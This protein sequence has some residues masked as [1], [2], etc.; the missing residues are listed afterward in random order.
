M[1]DLKPCPFCGGQAHAVWNAQ[2]KVRNGTGT[3]TGIGVCIYCENCDAEIRTT[4][5][6][7]AKEMWNRRAK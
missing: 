4:Q 2:I 1:D 5:T 7:L 3:H 6:H